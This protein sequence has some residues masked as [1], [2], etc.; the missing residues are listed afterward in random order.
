MQENGNGK[1]K[2]GFRKYLVIAFFLIAAAVSALFAGK[3]KINYN[4]SDYLDEKSETKVT[5]SVIEKEFDKTGDV[6]VMIKNVSETTAKDVKKTLENIE[7]VLVVNFDSQDEN[8]FKDGNAL[9]VLVTDGDEYSDSAAA[10]LGEVRAALDE[11]FD[12]DVSYGGTVVAKKNLRESIETEIVY[13]IAIAVC[14][15]AAIMLLTSKS[16]IEPLILLASSGVAILINMGTNVIFGEISYITNA[17]AAILQLA[18]SIDY[19]IVLLHNYRAEKQKTADD[20]KAMLNAVKGVVKP[21]SASALTTVAGLAALLFMSFKIGFDIGIVL[22]KGIVISAA[23]SLTF[24]PA[25]LLALDKPLCRTEKKEIAVKG[26]KLCDFAF[27]AHKA[28]VPVALV[29]VI[30]CGV[31]QTGNAYSFSD[32]STAPAAIKDA[33]G[34]NNAVAVVYEKGADDYERE[35]RFIEKLLDYRKADGTPALKSHAALSNTVSELYDAEK[36]A[37]K[38]GVSVSDA[39]LLLAM[40]EIYRDD[41]LVVMSPSDFAHYAAELIDGDEDAIDFADENTVKTLRTLLVAEEIANGSH[42]AERFYSL[43]ASVSQG[44]GANLFS[45]KQAYGLYFYDGLSD[46]KVEFDVMLDYLAAATENPDFAGEFSQ[47]DADGIKSLAQGVRQFVSQAEQPMSQSDFQA[48][49]SG[50]YGTVIDDAIAASVYAGYYAYIGQAERETIPYIDLM[51]YLAATG[52]ITDETAVNEINSRAQLYATVKAAYPYEEFLTVLSLTA[53]ALT[54]ETAAVSASEYAVQQIYIAYFYDSGVM[55]SEPVNGRIFI[56]F[57]LNACAENPF[58]DERLGGDGKAELSDILLADGFLSDGKKYGFRELSDKIAALKENSASLSGGAEFG[59]DET[60]G[61]YVKYAVKNGLFADFTVTARDLLGFVTANLDSNA[62]L[63]EKITAE[64]REIIADA[65]KDIERA[66]SLFSGENYS[67]I[68]LSVNLPVEGEENEKFVG[69]LTAAARETLG[70]EAHVAGEIISTDELRETF[71]KDNAFISVFTAISVFAIVT[72][73]FR[74]LS[75][76]VL[77]VAVI[78]GAIWISM[79]LSL[80]SGKIFF[81]S[82]IV[83]TCILMGT[84]ID[85][86]I[87]MS[88]NYVRYRATYDKK[89]SLYTSVKA[90]MPTVFT[91]GTILTVCGFVIGAIASQNAISTV[92]MLLGKGA[93]VSV[94]MITLVLPSVLYLC[95]GFILKFSLKKKNAESRSDSETANPSALTEEKNQSPKD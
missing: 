19:S 26:R 27:K 24:L 11:K 33:F 68:L 80:F 31:L 35:L 14:L 58:I 5:L 29:L 32:S 4:V 73:V 91:S 89:Q 51:T 79:S 52:V 56:N 18:L 76:P 57:L 81:M 37:V 90:A 34:N 13:I 53:Y 93:L 20:G 2:K 40:Y 42:T 82:Y 50:T 70:S 44:A 63:S 54:G 78:Q 16:W 17:V 61:V 28:V 12:G 10:V 49:M 74:S 69:Y 9:F 84:T 88:T 30:L 48:Y 92:G 39:K 23:T 87:L 22:I 86:G 15:V 94:L 47:T 77:L 71:T 95:D 66:E 41:S 3:V 64:T 75:I 6:Q 38:T 67:R 1:N 65:Q 60:S 83:T 25:I 62:L 7:N 85:Y 72:L 55:I 46:D 43:A 59:A 8:Y 36:A 21:V 45:V